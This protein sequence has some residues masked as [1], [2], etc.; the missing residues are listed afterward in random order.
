M[1]L[2]RMVAQNIFSYAILNHKYCIQ[3][4][5]ANRY[6]KLFDQYPSISIRNSYLIIAFVAHNAMH[7]VYL[8][9]HHI[10]KNFIS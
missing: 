8:L 9:P 10:Q 4:R 6:E 1:L 3:F 7:F 2:V 5:F